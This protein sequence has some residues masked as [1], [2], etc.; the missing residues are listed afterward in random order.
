L[1]SLFAPVGLTVYYFDASAYITPFA[2]A[3]AIC[4]AVF[5]ARNKQR[6]ARIF[7]WL[8]IAMLGW[9]LMLGSNTPLYP[10]LYH[11]PLL[12]RFRLSPRHTFEWT[13]GISILSAYGWD[14]LD[15]FYVGRQSININAA[16]SHSASSRWRSRSSSAR[17]GLRRRA[18]Y[19]RRPK[20]KLHIY[21]GKRFSFCRC[22]QWHGRHG[23][24]RQ[25]HARA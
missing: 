2:I 5:A 10:L 12:N 15:Q 19:S 7:F 6:D 23:S 25:A 4:A 9:T 21:V 16:R 14:A 17:A 3:L 22:L 20:T 8:V 1:R 13:F 11:V 18:V 24:L